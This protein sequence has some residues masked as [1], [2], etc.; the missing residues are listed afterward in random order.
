[1]RKKRVKSA[2]DTN[3]FERIYAHQNKEEDEQDLHEKT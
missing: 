1:V 2:T 3:A